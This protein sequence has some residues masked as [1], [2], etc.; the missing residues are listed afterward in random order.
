DAGYLP[1]TVEDVGRMIDELDRELFKLGTINV[2]APDVWGQNRMTK[3][4]TEFED[5]MAQEVSK[6]EVTL[7][8][9]LRRADLAV[10]ISGTSLGAAL[11]PG[12]APA[13]APTAAAAAAPP[14]GTSATPES[15]TPAVT[16]PS[17]DIA[18]QLKYLADRIDNLSKTDLLKL[19]SDFQPKLEPTLQ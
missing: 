13:S 14:S 7:N 1:P 5:Q 6:F 19:P 12:T 18:S 15:S 2:K 3:Y 9:A 16:P 17:P 10:L 11:N 8:G 4:R